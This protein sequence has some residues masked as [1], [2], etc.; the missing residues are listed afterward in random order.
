MWLKLVSS[1]GRSDASADLKRFVTAHLF[2]RP[3]DWDT[4][5][6]RV[7]GAA[8]RVGEYDFGFLRRGPGD[9]VRIYG[10]WRNRRLEF[11]ERMR[12]AYHPVVTDGESGSLWQLLKV[13]PRSSL[14]LL[15]HYLAPDFYYSKPEFSDWTPSRIEKEGYGDIHDEV[16]EEL[17]N[18]FPGPDTPIWI[19]GCGDATLG[20]RLHR[21]FGV[22]VDFVD[23][24]DANIERTKQQIL[25]S[26][27]PQENFNAV[28]ADAGEWR[29]HSPGEYRFV[30][31][32]GLTNWRVIDSKE[33][34]L[35]ILFNVVNHALSDGGILVMTGKTPCL[36]TALELTHA[37]L[38]VLSC[39][40]GNKDRSLY[41]ARK[42]GPADPAALRTLHFFDEIEELREML[43]KNPVV[44]DH[45]DRIAVDGATIKKQ[46]RSAKSAEHGLIRKIHDF[47]VQN[48]IHLSDSFISQMSIA[49][50][51]GDVALQSDAHFTEQFSPFDRVDFFHYCV[52]Q[53]LVPVKQYVAF[54]VAAGRLPQEFLSIAERSD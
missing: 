53:D 41:V 7:G 45:R 28:T 54:N 2:P 33:R 14:E 8:F 21:Q 3:L 35:K 23:V 1:R 30:L 40:N 5:D 47:F 29:M 36:F 52:L 44:Q 50:L 16:I 19:P 31:L 11:I 48:R 15:H 34:A 20:I 32:V 9:Q 12:V 18:Y 6:T 51:F 25:E 39:L 26:G 46:F 43:L 27:L 37:G 49:H 10:V 13:Q 42:V 38:E 17:T 22:P 24:L 4:L